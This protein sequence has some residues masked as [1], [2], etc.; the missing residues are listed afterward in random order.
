MLQTLESTIPAA[1]ITVEDAELLERLTEYT[2]K[3][4]YTPYY[5]PQHPF[6]YYHFFSPNSVVTA[7]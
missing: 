4:Y 6:I 1:C 5:P 7:V 3:S 2:S